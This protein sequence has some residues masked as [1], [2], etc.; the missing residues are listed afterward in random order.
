MSVKG[1]CMLALFFCVVH[2]IAVAAGSAGGVPGKTKRSSAKVAQE[3]AKPEGDER[4]FDRDAEVLEVLV[5]LRLVGRLQPPVAAEG[6]GKSSPRR[7]KEKYA[8]R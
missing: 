2:G 1:K 8:N 6:A 5:A 7:K 3:G 4:E